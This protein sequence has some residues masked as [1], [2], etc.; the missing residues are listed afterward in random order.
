MTKVRCYATL[1]TQFTI[2]LRC[3]EIALDLT[4]KTQLETINRHILIIAL[5][6]RE[7]LADSIVMAEKEQHQAFC[8]RKKKRRMATAP[9]I[10]STK[11]RYRG[12]HF[13]AGKVSNLVC[14]VVSI[15]V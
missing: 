14:L 6:Q 10:P 8:R 11:K 7:Q 2:Y 3:L 5:H 12:C 4:Q 1:R 9:G 15:T 13:P